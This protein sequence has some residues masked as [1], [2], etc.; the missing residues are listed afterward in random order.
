MEPSRA[1]SRRQSVVIRKPLITKKIDGPSQP[2]SQAKSDEFT[3]HVRTRKMLIARTPSSGRKYRSCRYSS[4]VGS[5]FRARPP[6]VRRKRLSPCKRGTRDSLSSR[7]DEAQ[8][9]S[10]G[11]ITGWARGSIG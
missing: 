4:Y 6:K 3:C 7:R 1:S 2:L 11:V 10:G 5:G 9:T 8:E